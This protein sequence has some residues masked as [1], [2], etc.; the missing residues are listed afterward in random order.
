L[1]PKP[2]RSYT[3]LAI[4][5]IMAALIIGS[6]LY[7]S[8]TPSSKNTTVTPPTTITTAYCTQTGPFQVVYVK[9][10][11]DSSMEPL[12]N[13]TIGGS[14]Q[15]NCQGG[16]PF[17]IKS[18]TSPTNG[19][20]PISIGLNALGGCECTYGTLNLTI[21]YSGHLYNLTLSPDS[22]YLAQTV[23]YTIG[24]PSGHLLGTQITDDAFTPTES[25]I[26]IGTDNNETST[27]CDS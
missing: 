21:Q 23:I 17:P 6:V 11:N 3:G 5:I 22:E 10:V 8:I 24:L 25:C 12:S 16:L 18:A 27:P 15:P 2:P 1:N 14:F 13:A 4:A 9:F 26:T 7:L 20:L 19:T